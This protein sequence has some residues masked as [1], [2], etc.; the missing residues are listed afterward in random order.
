MRYIIVF[1]VLTAIIMLAGC[2]G[3]STSTTSA[4][5][6]IITIDCGVESRID[7]ANSGDTSI[8]TCDQS[9]HSTTTN[10]FPEEEAV[11]L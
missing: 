1:G 3:D 6:D 10:N 2:D 11:E 8:N 9:D 4:G 5:G 7:D